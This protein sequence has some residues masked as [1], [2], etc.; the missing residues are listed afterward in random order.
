MVEKMEPG[1]TM[2]VTKADMVFL[3]AL[4]EADRAFAYVM[5][6][7]I[8]WFKTGSGLRANVSANA[9]ALMRVGRHI[10]MFAVEY[11]VED[12]GSVTAC[13]RTLLEWIRAVEQVGPNE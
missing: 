10:L 8:F 11:P 4:A 3:G 1:T 7:R 6:G 2:K 9:S 12:V 5:T 13:N